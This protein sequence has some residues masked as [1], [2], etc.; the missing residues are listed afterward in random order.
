MI[1]ALLILV[2][3]IASFAPPPL[4]G[5]VIILLGGVGLWYTMRTYKPY[6]DLP[7]LPPTP[8]EE[9]GEDLIAA[10]GVDKSLNQTDPLRK[11]VVD[12]VHANKNSKTK[13][14]KNRK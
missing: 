4:R 1:P 14:Y 10:H 5:I 7:S 2:I 9:K 3:I 11:I 12:T 13:K 6:T 8:A